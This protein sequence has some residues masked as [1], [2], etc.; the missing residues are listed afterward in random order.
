MKDLKEARAGAERAKQYAKSP[1]QELQI[2]SML[3]YLDALEQRGAVE[4]TPIVS[5]SSAAMEQPPLSDSPKIL[6][7][8]HHDLPQTFRPS[9]GQEIFSTW[10]Q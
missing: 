3:R 4:S 5:S 2:S 9:I 10:R 1:D 7:H 6:E 8:A